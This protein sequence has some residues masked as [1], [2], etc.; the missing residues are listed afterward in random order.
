MQ[1]GRRRR[2]ARES[3]A[4]DSSDREASAREASAREASARDLPAREA[5]TRDSPTREFA[6]PVRRPPAVAPCTVPEAFA[7]LQHAAG[8]AAVATMI[9]RAGLPAGRAAPDG[10]NDVQSRSAGA[11]GWTGV[12]NSAAFVNVDLTT[13]IDTASSKPGAA[14]VTV[15]APQD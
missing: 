6:E 4:W 10:L 1:T 3:P 13:S 11:A 12:K 14:Y 9:A 8:N 2:A 7:H 5:S 15:D